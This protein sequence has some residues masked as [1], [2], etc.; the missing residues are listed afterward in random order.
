MEAASCDTAVCLNVTSCDPEH[1]AVWVESGLRIQDRAPEMGRDRVKV[2]IKR[3]RE[4]LP[5]GP[6]VKTARFNC[7]GMG[8]IPGEG[9][10]LS[11]AP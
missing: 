4:R 6:V 8:S 9:T 5:G 2:G 11:Y 1:L 3:Q 10:K 7:R